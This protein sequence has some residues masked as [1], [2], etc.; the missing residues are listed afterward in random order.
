MERVVILHYH[1]FKNAGTSVDRIL[2]SN[3]PGKW[4]TA[5]FE[6][7]PGPKGNSDLVAQWIKDNPEAVAFS[8]HT[9][10]GPIPEIPGVRIISVLF[11]RDPIERIR[12]AYRFER[13]QQANTLG[14]RLA[15]EHDFEGYVRARLAIPNDRQCRNFQTERLASMVPG[16][17]PEL[18]RARKALERITVVGIVSEFDH[19]MGQLAARV[20]LH[21]PDFTWQSIRAN[22]SAGH[23]RVT[24]ED[25]QLISLLRHANQ[26]D[27]MLLNGMG[28]RT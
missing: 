12:S 20:Q 18:E 7:K 3:F 21:F 23:N 24:P 6:R 9:A 26:D 22:A 10:W 27:L 16:P 1:L 19:S 14:A 4:V 5:E 17:E 11:L 8:T 2:K 15:K 13:Q 28:S 25:D